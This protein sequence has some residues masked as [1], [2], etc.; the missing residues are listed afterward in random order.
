[1]ESLCLRSLSRDAVVEL[2]E[3]SFVRML[4]AGNVR[5]GSEGEAQIELEDLVRAAL[6]PVSSPELDRVLNMVENVQLRGLLAEL[7]NERSRNIW[8]EIARSKVTGLDTMVDVAWRVY[9]VTDPRTLPQNTKAVVECIAQ[10]KQTN[11]QEIPELRTISFEMN[12]ATLDTM[13][14]QLHTIRDQIQ[15]LKNS[16]CVA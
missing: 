16:S 4:N 2:L 13:V 7:L 8:R 5:A 6:T 1:M 10:E 12:K 14:N 15:L 11:A 3:M 9:T